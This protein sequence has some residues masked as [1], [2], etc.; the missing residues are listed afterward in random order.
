MPEIQQAAEDAYENRRTLVRD[1]LSRSVFADNVAHDLA[2]S[3]INMLEGAELS[4][5]V[6]QSEAPLEIAGR[7]LARLIDSYR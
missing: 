1:K 7:H 4:A 2:H 3:V 5:Q 6:T